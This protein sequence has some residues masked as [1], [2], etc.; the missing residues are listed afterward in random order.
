MNSTEKVASLLKLLGQEPYAH[1][2]TSLGEKIGCGK[3]GAYKILSVL[4]QSGLASQTSDH[5]YTLGPAVYILG[6]TYED[7]IGFSKLIKP[8]L[9][10]LRDLT[11]ENASLGMLV[12]GKVNMLYRE[13]S[14]QPVKYV[15][16]SVGEERAFNAGAIAKTLGAYLDEDVIREQLM[17]EPLKRYTPNT[18]VSPM[19]L[20]KE[21]EK[22]RE[23]GYAISDGEFSPELIGIGAPIRN[24]DG[25]VWAA[26][27]VGALRSRI[28]D[29]KLEH[30]IYLVTE[31]AK[32]MSKELLQYGFGDMEK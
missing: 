31:T 21:Y 19:D 18:I 11:G 25:D 6:K 5:K 3:S 14:R 10:R 7:K 24:G 23:R 17:R 22:I 12:N 13:E 30:C 9:V 29:A 27:S 15:G 2:V 28:D 4:V 20:L 32:K 8:Y 16:G 26:I 1:S